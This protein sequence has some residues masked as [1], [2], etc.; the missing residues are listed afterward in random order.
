MPDTSNNADEPLEPSDDLLE[1]V[2]ER[3][4][5]ERLQPWIAAFLL[6]VASGNLIRVPY[7]SLGPGPASDVL[8]LVRVD[9]IQTHPSEGDLLLTTASISTGALNAFEYLWV[10][11]D[12][13]LELVPSAQIQP[14]GTSER[15]VARQ[16]LQAMDDSKLSAEHAAYAALGFR[17]LQAARILSVAPDTAA[18]GVLQPNDLVLR[19]NGQPV[20]G[21]GR[22]AYLIGRTRPGQRVGVFIARDGERKQLSLTVGKDDEGK[23]RLGVSLL[24]AYYPRVEVDIDT[25][26]IGGPS[27]GLVFALA[28][29]EL[30]GSEDLTRGRTIAVTG[31]IGLVDGVGVVGPIGGIQEKIVGAA[32][33]GAELFIV[34]KENEQAA[35]EAAPDGLRIVG[36]ATLEEAITALRAD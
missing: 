29:V 27:G 33:A 17:R 4:R 22:L 5:W 28:L 11:A 19:F 14:P 24:N 9:G 20:H 6:I 34:P 7:Y 26:R 12:P 15:D 21:P 36:V 10:L 32:E 2:E 23:P 18:S 13:T 30:L 25:R 31:T 3:G 16:N 35:L 8:E 1:P